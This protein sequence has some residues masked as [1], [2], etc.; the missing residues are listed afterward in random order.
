MDA[1]VVIGILT[2][3]PNGY[4]KVF[5]VSAWVACVHTPSYC[6]NC[7]TCQVLIHDLMVRARHSKFGSP[8]VH[9]SV[10][11]ERLVISRCWHGGG[12]FTI[13]HLQDRSTLENSTN[14]R[15]KTSTRASKETYSSADSVRTSFIETGSL[16]YIQIAHQLSR[17]SHF[18]N[19]DT[20]SYT[21][22]LRS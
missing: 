21:V 19:N 16:H 20:P 4:R 14:L 17:W 8:D 15:Q 11:G 9:T 3:W 22:P 2:M 5:A 1:Q 12:I 7:P 6:T 13:S 10:C 18:T